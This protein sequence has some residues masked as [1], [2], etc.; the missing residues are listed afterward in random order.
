MEKDRALFSR[1]G[2]IQT[3]PS[4]AEISGRRYREKRML[5]GS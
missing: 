5:I 1:K 4:L 3:E 2:A